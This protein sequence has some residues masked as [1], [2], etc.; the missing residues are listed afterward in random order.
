V[1]GLEE[2]PGGLTEQP[3]PIEEPFK[4][5]PT[6][7]GGTFLLPPTDVSSN[8]SLNGTPV[9]DISSQKP[10]PISRTNSPNPR[11]SIRWK[12]KNVIIQLP[13]DVPFGL[14]SEEGGKPMPLT[15]EEVEQKM[16]TWM[17]SGYSIEILGG[18][19]G[20]QSRGIYPDEGVKVEKSEVFVSIPDRRGT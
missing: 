8:G 20:G 7:K 16:K 12:G 3:A 1:D 5:E 14:P 17:D 6:P 13:S 9:A 4:E 2:K 19:T 10:L 11:T 18:D 15:K